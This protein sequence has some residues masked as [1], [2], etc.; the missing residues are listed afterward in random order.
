MTHPTTKHEARTL[1]REKRINLS[2]HEFKTLNKLLLSQVRLLEFPPVA[3][4]HLF[5]P[6]VGN[7]EPDTVALAA[8]LRQQYP[9]IRLVLSK[10]D[11]R[12]FGMQHFVWDSATT[13]R[14]NRWGIP[15][16][17]NGLAVHPREIDVVFVPLLAFDT[18]GN[19]VGY[20]K[21]FYDR[22]LSECRP[23]TLKIGL[24]LF[25]PITA[26]ADADNYDVRLDTCVTPERIW[27]FTAN[28]KP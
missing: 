22:F 4:V 1:F 26:I 18:Q 25:G 6:M 2:D 12:T 19:R 28:T 23:D 17:E 27:R 11:N 16:P 3:T 5:L 8:W 20:G 21:G 10:S 7:R 9:S 13:L 14:D 24:S 15:E